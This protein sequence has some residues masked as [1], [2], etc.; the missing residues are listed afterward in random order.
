MERHR[1]DLALA[2][3]RRHRAQ[4][5]GR[6][7]DDGVVR[8][9]SR[10]RGRLRRARQ[11]CEPASGAIPR[12]MGQH[13]HRAR[14]DR[15]EGP[16]EA[17]S[18]R[19]RAHAERRDRGD[20]F[21]APSGVFGEVVRQRARRR[22]AN[23][24]R[25]LSPARIRRPISAHRSHGGR[26]RRSKS[27]TRRSTALQAARRR[28]FCPSGAAGT[29]RCRR[30]AGPGRSNGGD[31]AASMSCRTRWCRRPGGSSCRRTRTPRGP[32]ASTSVLGRRAAADGRRTSS[33]CNSTLPHGT[34]SSLCRCSR[35]SRAIEAKSK[36]RA[37]CLCSGTSA[38]ARIQR[39]QA[40]YVFVGT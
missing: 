24:R 20:R 16:G 28:V 18:V 33:G 11:P 1:R 31:G 22:R 10:Y 17:V 34:P 14:S 13:D 9:R 30:P 19:A 8:R 4:R 32:I 40:V 21:R 38:S 5:S 3:R 6:V 29:V 39:R 37:G 27:S 23:W 12:T 26:C 7:G 35:L 36:R 2:A 25:W 15:H